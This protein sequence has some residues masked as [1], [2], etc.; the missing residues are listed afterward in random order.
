[1]GD[2]PEKVLNF[3]RLFLKLNRFICNYVIGQFPCSLDTYAEQLWTFFFSNKQ[4]PNRKP[5]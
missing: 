5:A 3:N 1:M 4:F 2:Y